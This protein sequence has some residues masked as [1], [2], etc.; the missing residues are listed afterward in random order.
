[1]HQLTKDPSAAVSVG[2]KTP[3]SPARTLTPYELSRY[4]DYCAEMM[5]LTSKVAVLFAQSLPDPVVTDAVSDIERIASGMA[6]KVWQKI[7]MLDAMIL[8]SPTAL[9]PKAIR[10]AA[11]AGGVASQD[12]EAT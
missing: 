2:G 4:L 5:S 8:H 11:P 3:S 12:V 6:Q 10:P 1:M 7:M 9:Q